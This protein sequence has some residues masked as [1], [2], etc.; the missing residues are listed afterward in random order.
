MQ[1]TENRTLMQLPPRFNPLCNY[2]RHGPVTTR[3]EGKR[4]QWQVGIGTT[5]KR[6][7]RP[8]SGSINVM[9]ETRQ[10]VAEVA[11][12]VGGNN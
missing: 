6:S 9:A 12:T 2:K 7:A 3:E 8:Q 4:E 11:D 10:P 5:S 1:L